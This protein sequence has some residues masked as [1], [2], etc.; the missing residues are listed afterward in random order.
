M[1]PKSL[2]IRNFQDYLHLIVNNDIIIYI[3]S[4]MGIGVCP[5]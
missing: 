1:G 5:E 3:K 2:L 4:G